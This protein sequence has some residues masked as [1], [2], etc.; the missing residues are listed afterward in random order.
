MS[1]RWDRPL[2]GTSRPRQGAD[3]PCNRSRRPTSAGG[4]YQGFAKFFPLVLFANSSASVRLGERLLFLRQQIAESQLPPRI[5]SEVF[6]EN[7]RV[8][9]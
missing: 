5:S 3:T 7:G 6:D 2:I 8:F 1:I 9:C 4:R